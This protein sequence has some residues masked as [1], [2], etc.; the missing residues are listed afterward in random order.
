MS[1]EYYNKTGV[2][3][4]YTRAIVEMTSVVSNGKPIYE[5]GVP[6][7]KNASLYD[8]AKAIVAFEKKTIN[9]TPDPDQ[10]SNISVSEVFLL[11]WPR[12]A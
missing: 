2:V 4:N 3:A 5:Q 9:M 10:R 1:K 8:M 7:D 11:F 12:C 6:A